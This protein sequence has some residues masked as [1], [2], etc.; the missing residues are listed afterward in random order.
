VIVGYACRRG[1]SH[2]EAQ[3]AAQ[4]TLMLFSRAYV[5]GRYEREKGRLRKWMLAIAHNQISNAFRKRKKHE[6]QV[7][8]NPEETAFFARVG[9]ERV[10][11]DVWEQEW[12]QGVLQACLDEVRQQV[13]ARTMQA[14]V[15]TSVD[16]A[17]AGEVAE[18]LGISRNAVY[19]ARH[20]VLKRVRELIPKMEEIW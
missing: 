1:L 7:V 14:F 6:V 15:E 16:G 8:D 5:E 20:H 19:L 17:P 11:E 9:D 3:D 18:K 13:D 12:R 2:D 4:E 10:S